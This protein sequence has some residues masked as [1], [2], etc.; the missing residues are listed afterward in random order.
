MKEEDQGIFLVTFDLFYE[1]IFFRKQRKGTS[2]WVTLFFVIFLLK[3]SA[4]LLGST[5]VC[6]KYY[7]HHEDTIEYEKKP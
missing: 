2:I 3:G 1:N 4:K 6:Q 7:T 5:L